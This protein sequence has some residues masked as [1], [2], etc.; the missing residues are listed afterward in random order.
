M[1]SMEIHDF[2][3]TDDTA[4]DVEKEIEKMKG[5]EGDKKGT[6]PIPESV[7]NE[8]LKD[9]LES[10]ERYHFI[11][12]ALDMWCSLSRNLRNKL[13]ERK[14][15]A[16]ETN[17]FELHFYKKE[18]KSYFKLVIH[19]KLAAETLGLPQEQDRNIELSSDMWK[20]S[21]EIIDTIDLV[22]QKNK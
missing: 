14:F 10:E 20:F 6:N 19:N 15:S 22:S 8:I 2:K 18:G 11:T 9:I 5:G 3:F 4:R 13:T 1:N 16:E 21:F 17:L 7:R 12:S